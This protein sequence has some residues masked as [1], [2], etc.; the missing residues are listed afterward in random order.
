MLADTLYIVSRLIGWLYFK[1]F[2]NLKIRGIENI[3]QK[4]AFIVASNHVSNFDPILLG[5]ASP[6][7]LYYLAK[8]DLFKNRIVSWYLKCI[9]LVPIKR[10]GQSLKALKTAIKLLREG[11]P[12][13]IFPEGTRALGDTLREAKKGLGFLV[14]K[15]RVPVVPCYVSGTEKALPK[16]SAKPRHCPITVYIGKPIR[17]GDSAREEDRY[18]VISKK[19]MTQ[20]NELGSH[21]ES[22]GSR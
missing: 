8:E 17:F 2:H 22:N 13:V 1:L 11:E 9:R 4:E 20:I 10:G 15:T 21:H 3:P 18:T 7:F 19:V 14:A 5:V 16:G 12:L 6:R